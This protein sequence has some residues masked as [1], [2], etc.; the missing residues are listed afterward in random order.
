MSQTHTT[1]TS[2]LSSSL[3]TH[4]NIPTSF[5]IKMLHCRSTGQHF[6]LGWL[7]LITEIGDLIC[8]SNE[9]PQ[10]STD[11][12]AL[13]KPS[14]W[15]HSSYRQNIYQ[16]QNKLYWQRDL[17]PF[18][19]YYIYTGTFAG[20]ATWLGVWFFF[21]FLTNTAVPPDLDLTICKMGITAA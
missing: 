7:K 10:A 17:S 8:N 19:H 14:Y 1:A 20:I 16:L 15:R 3:T 11:L 6:Q 13:D 12:S 21:I 2:V 4:P 18:Q 5:D 9:L